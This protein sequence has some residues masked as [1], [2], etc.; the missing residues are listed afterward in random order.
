MSGRRT[1]RAA[2]APIRPARMIRT[3]SDAM[4]KVFSVAPEL[5]GRGLAGGPRGLLGC[6]R[7]LGGPQR[8]AEQAEP[9]ENFERCDDVLGE[10]QGRGACAASAARFP[11]RP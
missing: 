7:E 5:V 3:K 4:P 2:S 6:Y 8:G 9:G 11:T 1:A 10:S